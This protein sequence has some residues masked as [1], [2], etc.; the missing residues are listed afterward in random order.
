M[1][2]VG[3]IIHVSS[4]D[5]RTLAGELHHVFGVDVAGEKSNPFPPASAEQALLATH[6]NSLW[7]LEQSDEVWQQPEET[8]AGILDKER[9]PATQIQSAKVSTG[10]R[11][12]VADDDSLQSLAVE[13]GH[14]QR[15]LAGSDRPRGGDLLNAGHRGAWWCQ[16]AAEDFAHPGN[17]RN[18]LQDRPGTEV[19]PGPEDLVQKV[20][21]LMLVVQ[22]DAD[23]SAATKA[24]QKPRPFSHFFG[25]PGTSLPCTTVPSSC[26]SHASHHILRPGV[27]YVH[28]AV[29]DAPFS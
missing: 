22:S 9:D 20:H 27:S 28:N 5:T 14:P 18:L 29:S 3:P 21:Q 26:L 7:M 16:H 11:A 2:Q 6:K 12:I 19:T 10:D 15:K 1:A 25:G 24:V 8:I 4:A 17:S 13:A 23:E